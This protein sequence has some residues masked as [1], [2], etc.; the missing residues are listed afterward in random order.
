MTSE[1]KSAPGAPAMAIG[2]K[3]FVALIAALMSITALGIDT[4]LPALPEMGRALGIVEANQQQ[5]IIACYMLGFGCSQIVFGPLADRFG[6]KPIVMLSLALFG[7]T[8]LIA[9]FA[10]TFATMAIARALQGTGA[11]AGR[12]LVIS[13]VRDCYS[14]RQMARIMSLTYI[15]FLAAPILAPTIGQLILMVAPWQAIFYALAL[16]A[17]VIIFWFGL[18]L[19]ETLHPEYRRSINA[20][21]ILS[22][23]K[24]VVT[25]RYSLG[26]TLAMMTGFG[27][28][29]AYI[30]SSQQIFDKLGVAQYFALIFA[31]T[32]GAMGLAS[33]LNSRIVERLGSRKVS[34]VAIICFTI[35]NA[36]HLLWALLVSESAMSFVILQFLAMFF[37]GLTGSNFGA[38]A[39]EPMGKIAGTASSVQG[40]IS[41]IGAALIGITIGQT[42]NGTT[43]PIVAGFFLCG[44]ASTAIVYVTERGRMFH[45]HADEA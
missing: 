18:R 42:Y 5:W 38:M 9:S 32:A 34:H 33:Y 27:S 23:M 8:S 21:A 40:T 17:F 29:M 13:I 45:S 24:T 22:A 2:F 37:F 11:A 7:I 44:L 20:S 10:D 39:M 6:R 15:I 4:M 1:P 28:L 41:T 25:N 31:V 3:E 35:V 43:T 12:V 36:I 30:N 26:Y 19:P 14:G 16:F